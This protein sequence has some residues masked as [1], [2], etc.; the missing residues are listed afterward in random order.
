[1]KRVSLLL[2]TGLCASTLSARL[3]SAKWGTNPS[4]PV[5]AGQVYDLTLTLETLANEEISGMRL[6]QGPG[7]PPDRQTTYHKNDRRY[8]VLHWQQ[9]DS[10]AKVASIPAGRVQAEV[11]HVQTFGFMRTANTSTQTLQVAAFG[12]EVQDLPGEARGVPIGAFDLKLTADNPTFAPG[13]VR[14]LTASLTARE[15]YVPEAYTFQLVD[16]A[17]GELYPFRLQRQSDRELTAQAYFV[18]NATH[19]V[20]LQ[21]QPMR[22]FDLATR[23]VHEVQCS[24]L[25]L[26]MTVPEE[27]AAAD[28][29]ITLAQGVEAK[30]GAPLRF[31]PTESSPVIGTLESPWIEEETHEAWTR[32]RTPRGAGWIRSAGLKEKQ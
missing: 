14:L 11:T 6:D 18:V 25:K 2:L 32:V 8:T 22:A 31:S 19:D 28:T 29:M 9:R 17:S 7:R 15:G 16:T 5:Y 3:M 27:Q 4:A 12:Y 21:L 23:A 13:E 10:R 24:P 1:M 30:Q 26:R 20:T